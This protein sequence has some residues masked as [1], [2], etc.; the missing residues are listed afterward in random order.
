MNPHTILRIVMGWI[1][2]QISRPAVLGLTGINGLTCLQP[3]I[4]RIQLNPLLL[5]FI[6]EL[7]SGLMV[8][9]TITLELRMMLQNI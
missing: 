2:I 8:L 1:L 6:Q 9:L 7:S 4:L 3:P 5:E